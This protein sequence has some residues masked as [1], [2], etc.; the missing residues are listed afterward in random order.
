MDTDVI[1]KII[2]WTLFTY[3]SLC[4]L[5]SRNAEICET[6]KINAP[7]IFSSSA[8]SCCVY[9]IILISTYSA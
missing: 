5:F 4:G 2:D 8:K 9:I 3:K 6:L 7:H 1:W